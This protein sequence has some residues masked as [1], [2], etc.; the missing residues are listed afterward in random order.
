MSLKSA[1]Y[2]II[3]VFISFS[4]VKKGNI[5]PV[6]IK[7]QAFGTTFHMTYYDDEKRD[8]TK[9][10]DSLFHLISK[11][12]STYMVTS[13]ISRVNTG[14]TLVSVDSY[15]TEVFQKSLRIYKETEGVF[16]PTI[17]VLVNAWGF[18]PE[19]PA[20]EPD[21]LQIKQL[22]NYVGF[23][24]VYL[25]QHKVVKENDS[26]YFDFNAIAKGYAGDI[27]G[28]FFEAKN[29]DNYLLEI[30]GD[31]RAKG[32]HKEKNTPWKVGIERPNFDDTRSLQQ[33]IALE[34]NAM[35]TSGSYRKFK[36]DSVSGEKYAHILN[37]KTG[38]PFRSNLLSVSVIS[39]LDLADVDGYATA[40]MAMS[41][42]QIKKFIS[43]HQELDVVVIYSDTSG[44]LKTFSTLLQ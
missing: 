32:K 27:V 12:L 35:A 4:C 13:D 28:R 23:D 8:F 43:K 3:F 37:A 6:I 21:S 11:S 39:S 40:F 33:V 41:L 38:Y 30:G 10:V 18:G 24:K 15:F 36:T 9:Q 25:K 44:N 16:D 42:D 20:K 26:I 1:G 34:N 14:D 31:I 19:Q 29:I 17:G 22:L 5:E 7:G 2:I